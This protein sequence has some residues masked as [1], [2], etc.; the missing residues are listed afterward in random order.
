MRNDNN[1][2]LFRLFAAS[3]VLFSHCYP[4]CASGYEPVS[5]LTGVDTGGGLAVAMFF[6]ISGYLITASCLNSSGVFDYVI[7]RVLRIFPALIVCV[8][9]TVV[10]LGPILTNLSFGEYWRHP[11]THDYWSNIW[12]LTRYSLPGV[13]EN[14]LYPNAVNGSLWTLPIEISMYLLTLFLCVFRVLSTRFV[15]VLLVALWLL[16]FRVIPQEGLGSKVVFGL[17]LLSD[18]T[19][20]ACF[21]F[22][23]ALLYL[24]NKMPL[25]PYEM[26]LMA[27]FAF[28]VARGADSQTLLYIILAPYIVI[29]LALMPSLG[30]SRLVSR[31]DVSYGIYIY[32]FPVQQVVAHL[33]GPSITP[34]TMLVWSLPITY[35]LAVASWVFVEKPVLNLKNHPAILIFESKVR[36][37]FPFLVMI[38]SKANFRFKNKVST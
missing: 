6:V 14:N 26:A 22:G 3:L 4:L 12:F 24:H 2:D 11:M 30:L 18:A 9:A 20:L 5:V 19:K 33:V 16:Y 37:F 17:F 32:A 10:L 27:L 36:R 21:Y 38:E 25:K 7:K 31:G 29:A 35:M 23:G 8:A 28:Y 13:F 34:F 1:F 15:C